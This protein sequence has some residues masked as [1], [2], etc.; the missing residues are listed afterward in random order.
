[1]DLGYCHVY[2]LIY[3]GFVAYLQSPH[4]SLIWREA[5]VIFHL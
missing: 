3:S 1:M 5:L 4:F 2:I